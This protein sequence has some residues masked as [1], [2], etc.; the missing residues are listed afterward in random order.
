MNPIS[1]IGYL[2]ATYRFFNDRIPDEE[3][4]LVDFFGHQYIDYA[5]RVPTL[6]P[7][8]ST[9]ADKQS[10]KDKDE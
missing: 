4:A 8:V 5:K 6:M 3:R 2:F 7:F 1:L 9:W 10:K